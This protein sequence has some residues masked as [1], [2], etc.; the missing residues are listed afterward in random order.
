P[1]DTA[2]TLHQHLETCLACRST[3]DS[4]RAAAPPGATAV[5]TCV[6][7]TIRD[8]SVLDPPEQADEIGRLLQYRVLRQLGQGGMGIVFEAEDTRLQRRV[9]L[10]ITRPECSDAS[11]QQR[12]LQEARM[13]AAL[14]HDYI[15]AIYE[16]GEYKQTPYLAMEFL[17]G[18]T[19]E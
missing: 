9:A 8:Y 5:G 14:P 11:F 2:Q 7:A 17:A 18:E 12:F 19:L 4:L 10:K 3:L 13:A 6:E 16:V 15:A 1:V